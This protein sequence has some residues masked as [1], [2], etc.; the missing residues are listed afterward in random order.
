VYG[1]LLLAGIAVSVVLWARLARR[2]DRLMLVY[3]AALVGAFLGAKLAYL[4]A[5]GWMDF[6]QPNMW[7]RLATGKSILGALLGGYAAVELAKKWAG[8]C[9]V[10]GDWFA[11]IA[12]V[13]ITI[14]RVGCLLHGCCLGR[15]CGESWFTLCDGEGVPRW[16]A[17]PVEIL[18][19]LVMI[20]VFYSLRRRRKLAGQHFHIYLICYGLFRFA[21]EFLRDTPRV[22]AGLSGYHLLA[23]GLVAFG[24][25]AFVRRRRDAAQPTPA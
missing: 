6:G 20:A 2:D 4:V 9:G 8:Y 7:R 18:F 15:A 10:T 25:A 5:E 17:V 3:V 19:N 12:P 13:G 16:P 1:W 21:H 11:L 22:E 14:G 24:A 23:L